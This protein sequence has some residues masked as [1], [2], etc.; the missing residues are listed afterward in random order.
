M[1]SPR[2]RYAL[3]VSTVFPVSFWF[4]LNAPIT[5]FGRLWCDCSYGNQS[6]RLFLASSRSGCRSVR[7]LSIDPSNLIFSGNNITCKLSFSNFLHHFKN[8]LSLF[9]SHN[10]LLFFAL[11][12]RTRVALYTASF[13][14]ETLKVLFSSMPKFGV[15]IKNAIFWN[16]S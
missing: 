10:W 12:P 2:F 14:W 9:F 6:K 15:L 4:T 7:T 1:F 5:R 16:T 13:F 11:H 8:F 3:N